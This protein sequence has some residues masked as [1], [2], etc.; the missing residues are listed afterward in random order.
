MDERAWELLI[1]TLTDEQKRDVLAFMQRL[2]H[3]KSPTGGD[4]PG[5]AKAN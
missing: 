3:E 4:A 2:L 1:S 5:E